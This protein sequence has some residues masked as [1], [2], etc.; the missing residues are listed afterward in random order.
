MHVRVRFGWC[1]YCTGA[2]QRL[3]EQVSEMM[4]ETHS[5]MA[6][7][8][9]IQQSSSQDYGQDKQDQGHRRHK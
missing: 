1:C 4:R 7:M 3:R 5:I 9:E 2:V 6:M 8:A